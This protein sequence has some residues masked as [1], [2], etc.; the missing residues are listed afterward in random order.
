M[1]ASRFHELFQ[2]P[3]QT[4]ETACMDNGDGAEARWKTSF[5]IVRRSK[6]WGGRKEGGYIG[7][8]SIVALI[9]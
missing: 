3:S 5:N 1:E 2:M 7:H 9:R 4:R 6:C 8:V